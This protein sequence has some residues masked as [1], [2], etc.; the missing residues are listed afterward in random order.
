MKSSPRRRAFLMPLTALILSFPLMLV[1]ERPSANF[2]RATPELRLTF[3]QD[4][5]QHPMFQTEWWYLT[6]HLTTSGK[7][8]FSSP[9]DYGFQLTFFRRAEEH[10]KEMAQIHLAHAALSDIRRQRFLSDRRLASAGIGLAGAAPSYFRVFQL[11]WLLELIGERLLVH[12][13]VPADDSRV[14]LRLLSEPIP[15]PLLH[16]KGG[17]SQKAPEVERA[18]MYYSLPALRLSGQLV[19]RET[20]TPVQGIGWLDHEYMTNALAP[21]QEGW[22]WFSLMLKDGT[23]LMLFRVRGRSQDAAFASGTLQ[24]GSQVTH[25]DGQQFTIEPTDFWESPHTGA[26]YPSAWTLAVP[27]HNISLQ[28]KTLLPDQEH[29]EELKEAV[30]YF[31]GAIR[32][33]DGTAIGY[34]ELTGYG[35]TMEGQL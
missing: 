12:S 28:L 24:R 9:T 15:P 33:D 21:G 3:P 19:Q 22:D 4:H 23:N 16:G 7:D 8:I 6:G 26:K 1:G 17:Y 29:R 31:E 2:H 5:G 32:S 30:N 34:A 25:L 27:A 14:E 20:L 35:K 13:S 10:G 18:S 11:D